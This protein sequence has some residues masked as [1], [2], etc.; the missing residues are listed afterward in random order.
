M[1]FDIDEEVIPGEVIEPVMRTRR[2]SRPTSIRN[3]RLDFTA[4]GKFVRRRKTL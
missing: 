2:A 4:D 3:T 1:S